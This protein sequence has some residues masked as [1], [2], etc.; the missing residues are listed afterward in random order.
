M[1]YLHLTLAAAVFAISLSDT[2]GGFCFR[3]AVVTPLMWA[4]VID[5]K[6]AAEIAVLYKNR[7]ENYRY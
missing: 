1:R 3:A 6:T 4:G 5:A 7:T 2:L